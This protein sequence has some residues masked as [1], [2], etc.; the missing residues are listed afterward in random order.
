MRLTSAGWATGG[1][2]VVKARYNDADTGQ[3]YTVSLPAF[4]TSESDW[5]TDH[6][7]T[8]YFNTASVSG[9][10][11]TVVV[12]ASSIA[13][14]EQ[15]AYNRGWTAGVGYAYN[16]THLNGNVITGPNES[17]TG[18]ETWYTITAGVGGDWTASGGF[19]AHGY[20]YV[21]NSQVASAHKT[22]S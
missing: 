22:F 21:N 6:K 14:D 13:G 3:S 7:K 18:T 20:A 19:S 10:V 16:H 15:A 4:T 5:S 17:G 9:P 12:D 1:T 11:K 8:I 2:C